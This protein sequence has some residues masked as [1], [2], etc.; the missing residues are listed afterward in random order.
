MYCAT[1]P[2]S[3]SPCSTASFSF[4]VSSLRN[5]YLSYTLAV[6]ALRSP[7]SLNVYVALLVTVV[8]YRVSPIRSV[9]DFSSCSAKTLARLASASSLRC[10]ALSSASRASMT[11]LTAASRMSRGLVCL[12]I[13]IQMNLVFSSQ[14]CQG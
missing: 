5:V 13:R 2:A 9:V 4:R 14:P 11:L 7:G 1:T 10:L 6:S 3:M 8:V 12:T